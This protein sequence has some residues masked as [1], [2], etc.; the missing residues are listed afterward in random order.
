MSKA[1]HKSGRCYFAVYADPDVAGHVHVES[2]RF[3]SRRMPKEMAAGDSVLTYCTASY[4]GFEKSAAGW[5]VITSVD[6]EAR[7]YT[8]DYV[9]FAQA[10]P[11][12]FLRFAFTD[13]DNVRL[14]N[15]R[16]EFL[17]EISRES[18]AAVVAAAEQTRMP[19]GPSGGA[20]PT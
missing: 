17:F 12:D 18:F 16:R 1:M 8:Y 3:G 2:G 7:S 6:H 14:A 5:G 13:E 11:L 19:R 4:T 9:P 20:G 15:M 10:V